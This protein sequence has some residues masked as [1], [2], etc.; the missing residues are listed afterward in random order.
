[1][2]PPDAKMPMGSAGAKNATAVYPR[3][4]TLHA[5]YNADRVFMKS[6]A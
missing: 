6:D 2:L 5:H 4:N 1:M 3:G